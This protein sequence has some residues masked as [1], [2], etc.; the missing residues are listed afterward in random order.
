M[1]HEEY[2]EVIKRNKW[3]ASQAAWHGR[4]KG[5]WHRAQKNFYKRQVKK[6]WARVDFTSFVTYT[7]ACHAPRIAENITANN[8]LLARLVK[9]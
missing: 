6:S 8:P 2:L 7:M 4:R 9:K 5:S 3:L 1:T